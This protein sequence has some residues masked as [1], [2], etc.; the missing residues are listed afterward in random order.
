MISKGMVNFFAVIL[1]CEFNQLFF[2]VVE[3]EATPPVPP[4]V[5]METT[6]TITT[7]LPLETLT[8]AQKYTKFASSALNFDDVPTAIENLKKALNLLE[9]K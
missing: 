7:T 8:L 4:V 9:N 1:A 6:T 5:T 3:P 2:A